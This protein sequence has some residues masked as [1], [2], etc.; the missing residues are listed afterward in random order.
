MTLSSAAR[1]RAVALSVFLAS[2]AVAADIVT[3]ANAKAAD[4][5]SAAKLPHNGANYR[6]AAIIQ[7][8]VFEAVNAVTSRFP[9]T[10]RVKLDASPRASIDAAVLSATRS[11]LLAVTPSQQAAV[12]AWYTQALA[13]VAEGPAKAAGVALGEKTAAAVVALCADDGSN[14]PEAWR[15]VTTPAVYVATPLP[16]MTQWGKRKPWVL[17]R[18]DQL[19]PGKPPALKSETWAR[20]FNEIKALGA[21]N[22]ANRTAE[23]TAAAKFWEASAPSIYFGIVRSFA[24]TPGRDAAENARLYAAVA[25]GMDDAL[26]AVMDAKYTY[27][28]WR[29]IT[30][31]RNADTA[32]NSATEADPG[33]LPFIDTPQHPEYPC[34][35]CIIASVV[36]T[37]LEAAM[38]GGSARLTGTS[39]TLPG[40]T[41][42]WNKPSDLVAE[43]NEARICDGVHYRNSTV[44]G[45]E[46][47]KKLGE[48]VV[49]K[50]LPPPL[51]P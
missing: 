37:V 4:F 6:A 41:R 35:H 3:D 46:M 36:A 44:V 5:I 30:A 47:G 23:Q 29:P 14:L 7:V 40:L 38:G 10:G 22:S 49:A 12:E 1:F 27:K 33:W 13:A 9:A 2:T 24:A 34:A 39:A 18:P 17:L 48:L 15:P 26:V 16:L 25:V 45:T 8:A 20:D 32:Q 43:V 51:K 28:F 21:K 50:E 19:R 31:I 11:A 42:S